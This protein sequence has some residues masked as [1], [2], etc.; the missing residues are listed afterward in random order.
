MPLCALTGK[1]QETAAMASTSIKKLFA[2][3]AIDHYQ[4]VRRVLT[5]RIDLGEELFANCH[6]PFD[7]LRMHQEGSELGNVGEAEPFA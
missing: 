2:D 7:V 1:I 4:R 5:A 3:Q 6:E